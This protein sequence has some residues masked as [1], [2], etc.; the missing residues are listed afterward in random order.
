M[1]EKIDLINKR[2]KALIPL[3]K[4]YHKELFA[5]A[6]YSLQSSGKR[7]RPLLVL[8][9]VE[10]LKKDITE[11]IDPACAI[12]MIHTYSLIHDDLPSMDDDDFRRG[13][14]SLHKAY[15]EW[16]AILTGDY[17]LT[18]AFEI[19][20]NAKKL[21]A[22]QKIELIKCISKY[23]GGDGLIAG[24][25]ADLSWEGKS[26]DLK[27]LEFMHFNK[28]ATLFIA[29]IEF[30]CII[31]KAK[32]DIKEKYINYAKNFGLAFQ[33]FNDIAGNKKESSDKIHKK[34]TA[35][36]MLG[37]AKTKKLAFDFQKKALDIL[38]SLPFNTDEL[39]KITKQVSEKIS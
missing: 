20:S 4:K 35:V 9:T 21:S 2:L 10:S 17:L 25:V 26:I 3:S 16:L 1:K 27:K 29:A 32:K 37:L 39:E 30:G 15:S 14:P 5:A 24:Q 31:A 28:T 23:A 34:A 13:K 19:L 6:N 11:A 18:Y 22:A 38:K 33:F 12:E 7:I 36:S 8:L